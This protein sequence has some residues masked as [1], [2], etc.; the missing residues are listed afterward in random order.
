MSAATGGAIAVL[1]ASAW[2][3]SW[4]ARR[5]LRTG[6]PYVVRQGVANLYRPANQTRAVV[7]SLGFGAFLITTLF[8]VQSNLLRQFN[9]T[10]EASRGNLLFFDVQEDQ[11]EGVGALVKQAGYEVIQTTPIV[12]MRVKSV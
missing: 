9:L 12:T 10:T 8:L 1:V 2:L 7:L 3:L 5:A 11:G 4:V 6:W